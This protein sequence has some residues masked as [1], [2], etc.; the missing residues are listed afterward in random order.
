MEVVVTLMIIISCCIM[1]AAADLIVSLILSIIAKIPFRKTFRRGLLLL[2]VPPVVIAY[3]AA[4]GKNHFEVKKVE[5]EFDNLPDCFDGYRIIHISD[6]HA[7]SYR[8]RTSRIKKCVQII[9]DLNVDLIVFT[10]DLITLVPEEIDAIAS[11]LSALKAKDGVI[12][13]LGNHDYGTYAD[14]SGSLL[15]GLIEREAGLGWD[16][17]LNEHKVLHKGADSIVVVGVENASLSHFYPSSSDLSK[18][19]EGTEGAFRIALTHDPKHWET[20][21]LGKDYALTLSGHTHAMQMSI[22]GWSPSSLLFKHSKGLYTEGGQHL[23]INAG[24]GET[25]FPAR[26]GART[27][28]T[29]I[30]L[31]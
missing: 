20:E 23:Y 18:A 29:V 31:R 8:K 24:L 16:L 10:G 14:T 6:L 5:I 1:L 9:N 12:S 22:F 21:I 17:L 25:L 19:S 30:T 28:I 11:S 13:V 7:R 4:I 3:G 26:I 27:E 2:L 15:Q